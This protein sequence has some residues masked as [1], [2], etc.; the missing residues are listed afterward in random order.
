MIWV[1][2]GPLTVTDK[3][4]IV[5]YCELTTLRSNHFPV[6]WKKNT[7]EIFYLADLPFMTKFSNLFF[8]PLVT[9]ILSVLDCPTSRR[10]H[11]SPEA[12]L[13]SGRPLQKVPATA[14]RSHSAVRDRSGMDYMKLQF[15]RN[16]RD[17]CHN[18]CKYLYT[19]KLR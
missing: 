19:E 13:V 15:G 16:F 7:V 9:L 6:F 4:V 1:G 14:R 8:N 5:Y 17:L 3:L 10:R 18:V 12:A 11:A 2:R